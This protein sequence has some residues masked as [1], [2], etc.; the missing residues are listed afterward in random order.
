MRKCNFGSDFNFIAYES[1][2][3]INLGGTYIHLL[4][5]GFIDLPHKWVII[6]SKHFCKKWAEL[7]ELYCVRALLF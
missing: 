7:W 5:V 1:Q 6:Y 3:C 4:G 2:L